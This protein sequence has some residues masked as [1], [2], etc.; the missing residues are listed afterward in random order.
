VLLYE[1]PNVTLHIDCHIIQ[2]FILDRGADHVTYISQL[3]LFCSRFLEHRANHAYYP[4]LH[5]LQKKW[6]LQ[7]PP[8]QVYR[9]PQGHLLPARQHWI[10]QEV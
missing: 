10:P 5:V 3:K 2:I 7:R 8:S 1:E 9:A 4:P 6:I